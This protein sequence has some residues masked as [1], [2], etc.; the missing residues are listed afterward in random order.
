MKIC[1][2]CRQKQQSPAS[3]L[4]ELEYCSD[5]KVV[6]LDFGAQ[7]P[8]FYERVEAQIRHWEAGLARRSS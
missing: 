1:P 5:C 7:R 2:A 6:W 8:R 3:E 4:A